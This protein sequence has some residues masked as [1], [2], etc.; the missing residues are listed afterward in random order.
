MCLF[1]ASLN[2]DDACLTAPAFIQVY[3][4]HT[5]LLPPLSYPP[6]SFFSTFHFSFLLFYLSPLLP[7]YRS[8][9]L[10]FQTSFEACKAS[11][12]HEARS[13][14][15]RQC[16]GHG[17]GTEARHVS[18]QQGMLTVDS[19]FTLLRMHLCVCWGGGWIGL[20]LGNLIAT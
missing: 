2:L 17:R 1:Q 7:F 12:K 10:S 18:Y 8:P 15:F 3:L 16:V 14:P 13:G 6:L 9:L 20:G 19:F 4:F 5:S 11:P